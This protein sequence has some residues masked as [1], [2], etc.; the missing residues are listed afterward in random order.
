MRMLW[1]C[2]GAKTPR[3]RQASKDRCMEREF[4]NQ[5]T[6]SARSRQRVR[7]GVPYTCETE[8]MSCS[9]STTSAGVHTART[10]NLFVLFNSCVN[11][12]AGTFVLSQELPFRSS[13]FESGG[14]EDDIQVSAGRDFF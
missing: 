2:P 10:A 6:R 3:T 14:R 5:N 13:T 4:R 1:V 7:S 11:S 9:R 12:V 8:T